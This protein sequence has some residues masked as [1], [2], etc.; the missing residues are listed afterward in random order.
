MAGAPTAQAPILK[1][2]NFS[3]NPG[4]VLAVVGPSGSGK[5]TLARLLIGVW[6]SITGKVRLDGA[7]IHQWDKTEL[8]QHLG[9]LPQDVELLDGSIA[10]NIARFGAIDQLLLEEVTKELDLHDFIVALPHGYQ[11]KLGRTGVQLSGGQR[12]RIALAR[13]L[14]RKPAFVV[15]DE[16]NSSLDD[17]GNKALINA[18]SHYKN[19]NVTFVIITHRINVL[20]ISDKMLVLRDGFMQAFG[21]RDEVLTEMNKSSTHLTSKAKTDKNSTLFSLRT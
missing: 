21:D 17:A 8:G 15:L 19:N 9:Y 13:A 6:P 16:P 4:E 12:Q 2:I 10:E 20:S 18:I 3:L 14:Y 1:G 11:T 7:D 5:T